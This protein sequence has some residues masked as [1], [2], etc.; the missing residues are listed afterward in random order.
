MGLNVWN[1]Y[2]VIHKSKV[3]GL[4]FA[5]RIHQGSLGVDSTSAFVPLS[6]WGQVSKAA[7]D[8]HTFDHACSA[9]FGEWFEE[10]TKARRESLRSVV[11]T[12]QGMT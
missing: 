5:F 11:E 4:Q 3:D 6:Q 1:N 2:L 7:A 8:Q 10:L 12:A 9:V